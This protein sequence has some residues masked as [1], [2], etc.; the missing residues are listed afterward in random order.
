MPGSVAEAAGLQSGDRILRINGKPLDD[1][2]MKQRGVLL[3]G[4]PISLLLSTAAAN[5]SKSPCR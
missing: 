3:R 4:S 2:N 1:L 5:K